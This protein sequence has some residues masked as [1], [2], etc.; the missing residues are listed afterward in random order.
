MFGNFWSEN[1]ENLSKIFEVFDKSSEMIAHFEKVGVF[2]AV[3][4]IGISTYSQK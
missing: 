3:V 2:I 1:F 4:L